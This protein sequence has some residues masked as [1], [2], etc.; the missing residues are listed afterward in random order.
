MKRS[1][2]YCKSWFRAKKRPT[3]VW[4]EEQARSAH[5][6]KQYYTVLVDSIERP[7]C[8]LEVAD[9]KYQKR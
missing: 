8:F 9:K 1:N 6:N 2:F 3:E 7:Y 4:T 5:V